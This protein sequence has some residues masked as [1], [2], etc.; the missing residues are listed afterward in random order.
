[1]RSSYLTRSL[2]ASAA[3]LVSSGFAGISAPLLLHCGE[4]GRLLQPGAAFRLEPGSTRPC[5]YFLDTACR[6]RVR[7]DWD[8]DEFG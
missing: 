3:L 8:R 5:R 7:C 4:R 2:A 6:A 1:M